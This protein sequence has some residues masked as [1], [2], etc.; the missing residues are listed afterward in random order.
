VDDVGDIAERSDF[1]MNYA[2]AV[3][4]AA[5]SV[6]VSAVEEVGMNAWRNYSG[7]LDCTVAVD[8]VPLAIVADN[9]S[10]HQ[11]SP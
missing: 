4:T 3:G 9:P 8:Y 6:A 5:A 1:E 2:S 11:T 10:S 7:I